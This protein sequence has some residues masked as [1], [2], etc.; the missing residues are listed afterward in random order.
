MKMKL[1]LFNAAEDDWSFCCCFSSTKTDVGKLFT[2][3]DVNNSSPKMAK[4]LY[5]KNLAIFARLCV[6]G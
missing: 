4:K 6:E 5:R 1:P 3:T 2:N